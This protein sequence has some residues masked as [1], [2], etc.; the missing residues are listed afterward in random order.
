MDTHFSSSE[1]WYVS[2]LIQPTSDL[3]QSSTQDRGG[4]RPVVVYAI[5]SMV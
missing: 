1:C 4:L 5:T 2:I 3:A